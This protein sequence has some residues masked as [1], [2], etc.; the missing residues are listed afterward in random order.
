MPLTRISVQ[1]DAADAERAVEAFTAAGIP[2]SVVEWEIGEPYEEAFGAPPPAPEAAQ[3]AAYI[4]A[5]RA[6]A[7]AAA[8]QQALNTA[9]HPAPPPQITREPVKDRDWRTA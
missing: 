6:D 1:V 9:W 3:V 8:V 4:P 7:T 2:N 5:D